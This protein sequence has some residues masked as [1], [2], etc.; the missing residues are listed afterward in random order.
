MAIPWSE[1]QRWRVST[2]LRRFPP[3]SGCCEDAARA[4]L[5]VAREVDPSSCGILIKPAGR[6]RYVLPKVPLDGS[7]W[8]FH[9]TVR[10]REHYVDALT[11]ADGTSIDAY[12]AQHWKYPDPEAY[13]IAPIALT[14]PAP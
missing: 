11:G 10:A 5:P 3:Q 9:V 13:A 1:A 4:V 6:A 12:F 7:P 14:E 2:A 8:R